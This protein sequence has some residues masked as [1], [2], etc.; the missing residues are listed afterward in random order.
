MRRVL[1]FKKRRSWIGDVNLD[2]LNEQILAIEEDGW[3]VVSVT[4][5]CDFLGRISA[6]TLLIDSGD[7]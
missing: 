1:E 4:P 7:L 6:Y 2:L 5:S 3:Q